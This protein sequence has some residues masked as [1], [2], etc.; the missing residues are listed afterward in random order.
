MNFAI[1]IS[2]RKGHLGYFNQ[3]LKTMTGR[4]Y[5]KTIILAN[6]ADP[7]EVATFDSLN[8]A[9]DVVA[10]LQSINNK[11]VFTIVEYHN[12][13]TNGQETGDVINEFKEIKHSKRILRK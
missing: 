3:T 8:V 1:I 6:G 5:E 11:F 13:N 4:G 9:K 2:S 12:G 10:K 7:D